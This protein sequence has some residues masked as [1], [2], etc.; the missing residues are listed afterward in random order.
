MGL[1][2]VNCGIY[3]AMQRVQE[4]QLHVRHRERFGAWGRDEAAANLGQAAQQISAH[5]QRSAAADGS[6]AE[7]EQVSAA[8]QR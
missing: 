1:I 2:K 5:F 8:G 3:R 7:H 6:V 4:L